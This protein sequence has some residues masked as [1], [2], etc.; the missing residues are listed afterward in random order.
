MILARTILAALLAIAAQEPAKDTPTL[1]SARARW[2]RFSPEEKERA[3]ANYERF[4]ALSEEEREQLVERARR[5]HVRVDRVQGEL[6]QNAHERLAGMDPEKRRVLVREIVADESR[7]V[8]ARI[9][10]RLPEN[11][12]ERLEKARPQDR[13]RFLRQFQLQQRDRVARYAIGELGQRLGLP[14]DEIERMQR[15][16]GEER[17]QA[18]LDLRKRLSAH[19]ANESGLLPGITREQWDAWLALPPEEFFE[20]IQRYRQS[21]MWHA[22][23]A[24]ERPTP[25]PRDERN[26]ARRALLE[27][28]QPRFEEALAL[29][30]LA[31]VERAT[32]L[33]EAKRG[34]CL[35][36]IRKGGLLA[37]EE[38]D[39]LEAK[40]NHEFFEVVR[41][42]LRPPGRPAWRF[43]DG[44][45]APRR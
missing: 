19:D 32:R 13:A 39:A 9:R 24:R 11:W 4:I 16:P 6:M 31:P 12:L 8:G 3:R 27:A 10:G 15:L 42:L 43:Q 40:G 36:A 2:E 34:R 18:V 33:A 37:A 35:Q 41:R 25:D 29:A 38:I 7:E 28:A 21:R 17:G 45:G 26:E 23:T 14:P 30:D 1:Q 20:V 22:E 44:L 5:L